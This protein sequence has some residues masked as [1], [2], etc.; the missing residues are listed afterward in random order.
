M[1]S[2]LFVLSLTAS[3]ALL[4]GP[5]P[6]YKWHSPDADYDVC[7][8]YPPGDGWRIVQGPFRDGGC[9]KPGM[10]E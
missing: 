3:C 6:W 7:L 1:K 5:A 9:K 4:A 8:Q 10:P 2:L